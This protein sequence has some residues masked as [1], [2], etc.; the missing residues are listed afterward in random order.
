MKVSIYSKTFADNK[1]F[2]DKKLLKGADII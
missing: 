2:T 1:I